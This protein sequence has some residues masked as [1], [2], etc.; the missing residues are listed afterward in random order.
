MIATI[1]TGQLIGECVE[2]AL[3]VGVGIYIVWFWPRQIQR[4][5]QVGKISHE[6]GQSKLKKFNPRFGY[7]VM[8]FGLVRFIGPLFK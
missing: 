2:A 4:Q 7:L 3:W 8:L 5:V 6:Q 1:S